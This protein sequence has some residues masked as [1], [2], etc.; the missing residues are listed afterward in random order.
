MSDL[1]QEKLRQFVMES[2]RLSRRKV[3]GRGLALGL[4]VPAIGA[5]LATRPAAAL[6]ADGGMM[7]FLDPQLVQSEAMLANVHTNDEPIPQIWDGQD[8]EEA[9]QHRCSNNFLAQG[10]PPGITGLLWEVDASDAENIVFDVRVDRRE[11]WWIFGSDG[12]DYLV[13][14]GVRNGTQTGPLPDKI[15]Y[16]DT[17]EGLYDHGV[18]IAD[19]HGASR[20][21][22]VKV[23][24]V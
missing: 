19:V 2:G 18:Y 14:S 11:G 3:I 4:S 16:E 1:R 22:Y 15:E 9:Q 23:H 7:Q 10:N 13:F 8:W 21:F 6:A 20:D 12:T 24:S 5:L 17:S